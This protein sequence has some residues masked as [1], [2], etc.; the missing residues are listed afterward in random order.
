M[1]VRP[2][3]SLLLVDDNELNRDMVSRGLAKAGYLVATAASGQA[4]LDMLDVEGFDLMLLDLMMPDM[5][6]YQVLEHM[7]DS[8]RLARLPVIVLSAVS[9]RQSVARCMELGA[10]DYVIKPS[11]L[12]VLKARIW[13][14]LE[15]RRHGAAA[16]SAEQVAGRVLIVDDN[17]ANLDILRRRLEQWQCEVD[18]ATSGITAVERIA[19]AGGRYDLVLLDIAM[20][21]MDGF[22]VLRFIKTSQR[23]HDMA[24]VVVSALDDSGTIMRALEMGA[25]DFVRK[26]F[27]AVELSVRVQSSIRLARLRRDRAQ[28]RRRREDLA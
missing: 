15:H 16:A 18:G 14:S 17:E 11:E 21:G 25:D 5:D 7:R 10:S 24:V 19:A 3:Y 20:P 13:R 26:P 9:G 2:E 28:W 27:N 12:E 1:A 8:G 6:G 4:A 22:D 23:H